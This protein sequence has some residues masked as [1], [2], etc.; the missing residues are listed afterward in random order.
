MGALV[1]E[2]L[3]LVHAVPGRVR[4]HLPGRSSQ[5]LRGVEAQLRQ[6]PGVRSAQ[7]NPLTSNVLVHFD[8][9]ASNAHA[10]LGS[11]RTSEEATQPG[12]E[13][14]VP[15]LPPALHERHGRR[16][17]ARIAVRGLDRDPALARGIVD[18]LER[19][20]GVQRVTVSVLTGRV[21][22]EFAEP[23]VAFDDLLND[24]A[25]LELP[26]MPGEDR[27]THPLESGPLLRNATRTVVAALG[28]G[29]LA[30][31]RFVG[32]EGPPVQAAAP[33]VAAG[34]IGVLQG[35][36]GAL[37]GLR[38][39]L[40]PDV[41]DAGLGAAGLVS[42]TLAGSPLGLVLGGLQAFRLFTEA[43]ARREAWRRY[44]ERGGRL[45]STQPG[46]VVHLE[47]GDR[48]PLAATVREGI[49][50]AV[51]R[52][53]LPMA[54]NPGSAIPAGAP[55]YGGPFVLELRSGRP[56]T[57]QPRAKPV[58]ASFYDRYLRTMGPISLA[59]AAVTALMTRSP[60]RAFAAL[61]LV[62]P[63]A[64]VVGADTADAG[65]FARVLRSGVT[66]VG[67]R[68]DR[69]VRLPKILLLDGPR[70]LTNGFELAS[71]VPLADGIEADEVRVLAMRV[72]A[73]A[74]SPW[75]NAF[76]AV[77]GDLATNGA[78]NGTMASAVVEGVAHTL[79]PVREPDQLPASVRLRHR[80]H[81][82]LLL[83]RERDGR[84]LGLL[85]LRPRLAPGTAE[86]VRVCRRHRVEIGLLG[87]GDLLAA[88]EVAQRAEVP[89]LDC[90]DLVEAVRAGQAREAVVAVVSDTAEAAAAFVAC[91]LAI[92]I[93]PDG[94]HLP[95]RA[96]LLASDLAAVAAI[97]EAGANREA[98]IRDAVAFSVVGNGVGAVWGFSGRPGIERTSYAVYAA[99][100]GALAAG[101]A[102][103]RGGERSTSAAA[104]IVD[105]HPERW[106][107]RSAANVL[108]AFDSTDAG[109]TSVQAGE[110][111]RVVAPVPHRNRLL[112]AVV[113]QIRSPL[114]GI[115]AAGAGLSLILG[116]S[117]DALMIGAMVVANAA[118]GA[119]Q[120]SRAN[121][122]ADALARLGTVTTRVLRDG[123][124]LVVPGDELVPGDV[125]L[126]VAG[127]RVA[128]DARLLEAH[129]LEL[130]EAGLTGESLP[131]PKA[132]DGP[133]DGSR[134]VL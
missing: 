43:R 16:T 65:A 76:P 119:W 26:E 51:G 10:I 34:A 45:P 55:L 25:D 31:R 60:A 18:R 83:H 13:S 82:L 104:G 28:L 57:T 40:G 20:P 63:R 134:V 112:T 27:P 106:G 129:G 80:G 123:Q 52:D 73:A 5:G 105:P 90:D 38:R 131:V 50:V 116:A 69:P 49:G 17:R 128:A 66:V 68:P 15:A 111:R 72:A 70:V 85:A 12:E 14:R 32:A 110:R 115:L 44:E 74:G 39:L 127:D 11:A 133:T 114:T 41:V 4:L 61:L 1:A 71:V 103:Q 35:F 95:A 87:G 54:V 30:V 46:A 117:A 122:A 36:P 8:P 47:A 102:R 94:G 2:E 56:F 130:D 96:D 64:A 121:Q 48:T 107:R 97:V 33:V 88:Q 79:D 89:L 67:T 59:Y 81:H 100:F 118:A 86:L 7:A 101:W 124:V 91:D 120:E 84:P 93:T 62:N 6:T 109:L 78:F 75:G 58:A 21:L 37:N 22:V 23:E 53:G 42:L 19:R 98:T 92:G 9:M 132:P 3:R 126:L 99:T 24:V 108:H 125:M 113:D 29:L 77:G